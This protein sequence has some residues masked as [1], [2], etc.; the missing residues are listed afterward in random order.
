MT[1]AAHFLDYGTERAPRVKARP[2]PFNGG[3]KA[4]TPLELKLQEKQRLTR[5]YKA[6]KRSERRRLIEA[7]P[8]L[9]NLIR[10]VRKLQ[11][12][13]G[14]ELIEAVAACD[15]LMNSDADTR[16]FALTLIQ[17]RADRINLLLGLP[18]FSDPVPP[19]SNVY[20]ECRALLT[21][22]GRL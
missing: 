14:D 7:E 1:G 9:L 13:G 20:L 19:E 2:D 4:P 21:T 17:N 11:A 8:R 10:F 12:D 22:R 6:W 16:I 5:T 3:V 15:W 18:V